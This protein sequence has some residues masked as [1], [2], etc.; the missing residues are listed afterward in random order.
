MKKRYV[1]LIT[2]LFMIFV[3]LV[4]SSAYVEL[5]HTVGNTVTYYPYEGFEVYMT[6]IC[7][8]QHLFGIRL[9]EEKSF[10]FP[11]PL[12]PI[13]LGTTKTM[14]KIIFMPKMLGRVMLPKIII[15]G[16]VIN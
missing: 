5:K 7:K 10:L 1:G 11:L 13:G 4:S 2:L 15:G 16:P 3:S 8:M 9:W 14:E 6:T 12:N